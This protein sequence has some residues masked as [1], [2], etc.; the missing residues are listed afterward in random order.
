MQKF[1]TSLTTIKSHESNDEIDS[2][3]M[4][5]KRATDKNVEM[6]SKLNELKNQTDNLEA[7]FE[8]ER[9]DV[10]KL[11]REVAQVKRVNLDS[12]KL[13]VSEKRTQENML[14]L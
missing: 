7:K 14:K 3:V 9:E 5:L 11:M 2:I 12:E 6:Y 8:N 1:D 4:T 10:L 13:V